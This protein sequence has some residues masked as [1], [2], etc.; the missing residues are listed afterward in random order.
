MASKAV[1]S[2]NMDQ[3]TSRSQRSGTREHPTARKY[4]RLPSFRRS[5]QTSRNISTPKPKY[6][7]RKRIASLSWTRCPN[8]EVKSESR[9][10]AQLLTMPTARFKKSSP[11]RNG[12]RKNP[13]RLRRARPSQGKNKLISAN[14][15][16][17]KRTRKTRSILSRLKDDRRN[18]K[19]K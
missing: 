9:Q 5:S 1:P 18:Q 14:K 6:L 4:L 2:R 13:R 15:R 3:M 17:K 16:Y 11:R 10:K 8:S 19:P 12:L 7:E